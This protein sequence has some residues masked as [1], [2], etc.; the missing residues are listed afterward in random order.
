M[1]IWS[2]GNMNIILTYNGVNY[3]GQYSYRNI[4]EIHVNGMIVVIHKAFTN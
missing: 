1:F 3:T 4:G 2:Y